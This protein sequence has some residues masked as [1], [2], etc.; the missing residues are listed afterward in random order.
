MRLQEAL[1]T[2]EELRERVRALETALLPELNIPHEWGVG[3]KQAAVLS[4]ILA[5][6]GLPVGLNRIHV[7]VYGHCPD[8]RTNDV[9]YIHVANLRKK[10]PWLKIQNAYGYGWY[11][12]KQDASEIGRRAAA[13]ED[14]RTLYH[15]D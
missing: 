6:E 9:I 13:Q 4:C 1:A 11:I 5:G 3:R 10:L 8:A 12:T 2:I 14:G 7:A 15:N